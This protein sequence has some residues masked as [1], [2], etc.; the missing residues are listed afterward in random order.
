[1]EQTREEALGGPG[2]PQWPEK[3][4]TGSNAP[5]NPSQKAKGLQF[6]PQKRHK[7]NQGDYSQIN[8][9]SHGGQTS[10]A[11]GP[12]SSFDSPEGA[13][14]A[15]AAF[16]SSNDAQPR[17]IS[18][19]FP[20]VPNRKPRYG[21]PLNSKTGQQ[22]SSAAP[23]AQKSTVA[24]H[25]DSERGVAPVSAAQPK[26]VSANRTHPRPPNPAADTISGTLAPRAGHPV[27]KHSTQTSS[28]VDALKSLPGLITSAPA[29]NGGVGSHSSRQP[30][31]SGDNAT[32]GQSPV[33]QL[34]ADSPP[35]SKPILKM[36]RTGQNYPISSPRSS[37]PLRAPASL[38]QRK[39]PSPNR[40][41]APVS[42]GSSVLSKAPE[43]PQGGGLGLSTAVNDS[44]FGEKTGSNQPAQLPI[45][46]R[47]NALD[48]QYKSADVRYSKWRLD[49]WAH[50]KGVDC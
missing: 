32:P 2:A 27:A 17:P 23:A 34:S 40:K 45:N 6:K 42:Q 7:Q 35:V 20:S 3:P 43:S 8:A 33:G 46:C 28:S 36:K 47:T 4:P 50:Y 41:I 11:G 14:H 16:L 44:A 30:G 24:S 22:H 5:A 15:S 29:V 21:V 1:M 31:S 26:P 19:A 13:S 12:A 38:H 39:A 25:S 18:F 10:T 49:A 48:C 37:S 9:A